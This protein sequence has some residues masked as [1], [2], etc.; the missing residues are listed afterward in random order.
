MKKVLTIL[1]VAIAVNGFAQLN[2]TELGNLGYSEDLSDIWGWVDG[3]GTEYALVGVY[4]GFSVVDLSNV[5]SPTEVFFEAGVNSIWRDIKTWNNHAY[6]TTEGGDGLLIVD[7]STLPGN[8]NLNATYFTGIIYPFETAHN[9]YIDENGVAY[10]FGADYGVGGAIMLDLTQDPMAPV[11][12]GVYDEYYLHDGMVR[13]DTMYGSHINDGFQSVI[14]VSNKSNAV[15]IANW[16]TPNNFTHNCWVSDDG[17]YIYTTDEKQYAYIG[18]YDISD[19]GNVTEVDRWQSNPGAGTIPHNTHFLNEYIVTSYYADGLSIIDVSNP[20]N[21]VEVGNYDTSPNYAG[22]D[23]GGFHGAWGTYPWLPSGNILVSDIEEG[24]FII[25][26][27]YMRACWLEGKVTDSVCGDNLNDVVVEIVSTSYIEST[28]VS[29]NYAFGTPTSGTYSVQFSKAGYQTK[30]VTG[31]VLTNGVIKNID[32]ELYSGNTVNVNGV[33]SSSGTG[34]ANAEV[35]LIGVSGD[36]TITAN[37]SGIYEKCN[38]VAGTYDVIVSKWGYKTYCES[39]VVIAT[40]NSIDFDLEKAYYDD[41]V[42]DLGWIRSGSASTGKWERGDPIGTIDN[43]G[44]EACSEDDATGA[45]CGNSAYVTGNGGGNGWDDDIDNGTTI[46]TSPNIDL[47]TYNEP[48]FSFYTWFMNSGGNSAP[49]DYVSISVSNGTSTVELMNRDTTEAMSEWMFH[50]FKLN[51]YISSTSN[52]NVIVKAV[53]DDPGNIVEAG[54]DVFQIVDSAATGIETKSI[55]ES[56][57][58]I[59]FPNPFINPITVDLSAADNIDYIGVTDVL[60][61]EL[62]RVNVSGNRV[63]IQLTV[64][65]GI[66]FI[67]GYSGL[68]LIETV[69]IIKE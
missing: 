64:E 31:V 61:K 60:G 45:D 29:G 8:T 43:D 19:L 58:I 65:S 51:D 4:D 68:E 1:L 12:L 16:A 38:V 11:E 52:M 67:T 3:A 63:Q 22:N 41:F 69:R 10:I 37:S 36:Y 15:M 56:N 49:N 53:D 30:T 27:N 34:I 28:N 50:N 57:N 54:F 48:Y 17:N 46:I 59:V 24:L 66:Y 21:L 25:G 2:T 9:L 39:G 7:L 23:A 47:S 40:S 26:P 6:V 18:A 62:E 5:S 55:A 44:N 42:S 32:V 33:V 13:G 14:D 35:T 20:T